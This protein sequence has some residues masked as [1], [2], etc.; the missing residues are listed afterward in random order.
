MRP[1]V[2]SSWASACS[3]EILPFSASLATC[4]CVT[5]RAFASPAS[6]NFWST[7]LSRTGTSAD[8]ITWAISPPMTPEPTTAALKTNMPA[9]LAS[10]PAPELP[11]GG[12][13]D[14]EARDRAAHGLGQA[15]AQEQPLHRRQGGLGLA[16][17]L[18]R[19]A[20]LLQ[21]GLEDHPAHARDL[22]VLD[23]QRLAE[24]RLVAGDPLPVAPRAARRR[25]PLQRAAGQRPVVR[26]RDDVAEPVD[27]GRPARLVVPHLLGL[28]GAAG[29][30]EVR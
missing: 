18:Q 7:S 8:A 19:D 26:Q 16:R 3:C 4:R 20:R 12:E 15:P 5:S 24:P 27:P 29:A 28:D 2:C 25:V 30:H 13:L 11:L 17:Q 14:G 9:T 23:L 22:L 21:A 10:V 6:T 1:S